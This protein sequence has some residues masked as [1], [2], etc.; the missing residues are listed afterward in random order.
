MRAIAVALLVL[1]F[2][3]ASA[4]A[5]IVGGHYRV[6]GTNANGSAYRGTA[7][8]EPSSNSTCRITWRTGTTS[9]GI[10]MAAGS[11]FAASYVLNG[12]V[13][14][15]VYELQPSGT[16]KGVWTVADQSGAGTEVLTP[17]K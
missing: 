12:K 1:A 4:A 17:V 5:Q 15:V 2:A 13:G 3:G 8:I 9:F 6:E 10:C 7:T 14:L 16:L 11:A